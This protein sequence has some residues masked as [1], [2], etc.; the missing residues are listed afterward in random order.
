MKSAT[1]PTMNRE[2]DN[3]SSYD[4]YSLV[5]QFLAQKGEENKWQ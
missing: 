5:A 4:F 3:L 1:Q 2:P